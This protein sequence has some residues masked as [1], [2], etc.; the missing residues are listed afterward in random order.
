MLDYLRRM[1]DAAW[2]DYRAAKDDH[3]ALP[4]NAPRYLRERVQRRCDQA[5]EKLR[6]AEARLAEAERKRGL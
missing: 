3:F 4:H 6:A 2:C 1:V 5:L